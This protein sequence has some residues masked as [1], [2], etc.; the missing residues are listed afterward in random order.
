MA[1]KS[2]TAI[3]FGNYVFYSR[4]DRN[5]EGTTMKV[6]MRTRRIV[7]TEQADAALSELAR[8]CDVDGPCYD[9]SAAES[10]SEF[11]AMKWTTLCSQRN[12]LQR[13]KR[14]N[15]PKKRESST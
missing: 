2:E 15:S 14:H 6:V 9:E 10:M 8:A 5:G 12:A 11:D 13:S 3:K 7:S 1:S 4:D